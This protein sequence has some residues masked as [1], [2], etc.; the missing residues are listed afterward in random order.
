MPIRLTPQRNLEAGHQRAKRLG[1]SGVARRFAGMLTPAVAFAAVGLGAPA[2]AIHPQA[3]TSINAEMTAASVI[4]RSGSR[5]AVV[6]AIQ[7]KVGVGAD[8]VFGPRTAVAVKAWQ[9]RAHLPATGVVDLTTYNKM[10]PVATTYR[11]GIQTIGYSVYGRPITLTV[12]GSPTAPKRAIFVGAIHG[13]E[14]GG[15]PVTNALARAKPPA[16]VAYFVISIPNPD[17]AAVHTRQNIRRVDLNRNFPGWKRNGSPGN[18]YYPGSGP[19]S[20][21]ES[22][23]MYAAIAKVKPTLFVTYHQHLNVVDFGGGNKGAEATYARQ[24]GMRFAQLPRYPGSQATWLHAAYP[25]IAVMTVEL[26]SSVPPSMI[27]RHIGAA[28][29]LAAHH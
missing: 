13:N 25:K 11:A 24:T 19:L 27:N 8:G 22:R 26:P 28:K 6:A 9:R 3:M 10:F 14:R 16:G 18:V 23:A 4:A 21:P 17:G 20:E 1:W 2:P 7:R 5:G 29:Y 12:V 15:V